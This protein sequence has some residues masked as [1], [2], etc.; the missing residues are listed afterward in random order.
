MQ[1]FFLSI[2]IRPHDKTT[3]RYDYHLRTLSAVFD[4][5]SSSHLWNSFF[6]LRVIKVCAIFI[7]QK[8][9][10]TDIELRPSTLHQA[11]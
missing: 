4:N 1:W 7:R 10:A 8:A 2:C 6:G 11:C 5:G 9:R 3:R